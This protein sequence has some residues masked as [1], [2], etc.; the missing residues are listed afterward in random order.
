MKIFANPLGTLINA[1]ATGNVVF[2]ECCLLVS[3]VVGSLWVVGGLC[4]SLWVVPSKNFQF[5]LKV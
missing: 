1:H 5:P 3:F 4:G 2:W